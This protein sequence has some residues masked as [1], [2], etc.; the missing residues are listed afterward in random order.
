[1]SELEIIGQD[2]NC[3]T[4]EITPIY[5]TPEFEAIQKAQREEAE[6]IQAAL[7]AEQEAKTKAKASAAAKLKGLGLSEEEVAAFLS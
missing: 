7:L 1:M 5:L 4:G 6:A 3:E 2:Y